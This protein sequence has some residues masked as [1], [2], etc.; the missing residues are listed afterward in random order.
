MQ[1]THQDPSTSMP[2]SSSNLENYT[3]SSTSTI[4]PSASSLSYSHQWKAHSVF[5]QPLPCALC[6]VPIWGLQ[7]TGVVQCGSC[8]M[9]VHVKCLKQKEEERRN[10]HLLVSSPSSSTGVSGSMN[11]NSL[12]AEEDMEWSI[13]PSMVAYS[14]SS[15][16]ESSEY[17]MSGGGGSSTAAMDVG[18][19]EQT[20][21][22]REGEMEVDSLIALDQLDRE[23][24]S[25]SL[26]REKRRAPAAVGMQ[27]VTGGGGN[28]G[29]WEGA[30]KREM[31][32]LSAQEA[33]HED[34]KQVESPCTMRRK[35]ARP[36]YRQLS[37]SF[38][39]RFSLF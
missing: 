16:M 9:A 32:R 7:C 19:Q 26:V 10:R 18:S 21:N 12:Q 25:R 29:E 1:P 35:I 31:M 24:L 11:G 5:E 2:P 27:L 4:D 17:N 30:E 6:Q 34:G 36:C 38:Q 13:C 20:V 14:S 33:G 3:S 8:S 15:A 22:K 37:P 28:G 23:S 39:V